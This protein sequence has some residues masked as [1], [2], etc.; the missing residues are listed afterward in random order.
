MFDLKDSS[1]VCNW[2]GLGIALIRYVIG[3]PRV[4]VESLSLWPAG[5]SVANCS[6]S[7]AYYF[8]SQFKSIARGPCLVFRHGATSFVYT[9]ISRLV[10]HA[11][12]S[13]RNPCAQKLENPQKSLAMPVIQVDREIQHAERL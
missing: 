3:P 12:S 7:N 6:F 1:D 9:M 11:Q 2:W 5:N 8:F 10:F 13:P 4:K